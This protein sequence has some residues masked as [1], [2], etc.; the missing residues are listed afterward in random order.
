[1]LAG[2]GVQLEDL[3]TTGNKK[4]FELTSKS[5]IPSRLVAYQEYLTQL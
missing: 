3:K 5:L 2:E 1:M 4:Y